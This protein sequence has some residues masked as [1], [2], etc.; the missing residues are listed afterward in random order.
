MESVAF[1]LWQRNRIGLWIVLGYWAAFSASLGL[2]GRRASAEALAIGILFVLLSYLFLVAVFIHQDSDVA[3]ARSSYPSYMFTLPVKTSRL[4]L[5]PMILGTVIVFAFCFVL[6]ASAR[7]SGANIPLF[8][9]AALATTFIAALQA[10]FWFPWGVPYAKLVL[11]MAVIALLSTGTGVALNASVPEWAICSA[12]SAIAGASYMTAYLGV[13][14]A[15]RGE[16][17]DIVS[18]RESARVRRPVKA[19]AAF[20][21]ATQA[22]VWYELRQHG[23]LLPAIA[24]ILCGLF[25]IPTVW[26]TT[27]SPIY[28]LGPDAEGKVPL[29]STYVMA[30]Y[31][32]LLMLLP[33]AAWVIGCG[34]KRS[35]VKR[36]DRTFQLFYGT[37]PMSDADLVGAKLKATAIS[38]L[39]AWAIV[40]VFS[41]PI[42]NMRGGSMNIRTNMF[43]SQDDRIHSVLAPFLDRQVLLLGFSAVLLLALMTW[44]NYAIGFWTELS[45]KL[46][47]RYAYPI[48]F[49]IGYA[50]I[51]VWGTQRSPDGGHSTA[52]MFETIFIGIWIALLAKLAISVWLVVKEKRT[53]LLRPSALAWSGAFFVTG[54]AVFV[55]T[56]LL[57]SQ[58][59]RQSMVSAQIGS[60]LVVDSTAIALFLLWT[61]LTR[62]L[63]APLML[64]INRHRSR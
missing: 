7:H 8:W 50:L 38:T 16:N 10:I 47:L 13:A 44:R 49:G 4:V 15:R 1:A 35:D 28:G 17:R 32:A 33:C 42:L 53:G 12:L 60:P 40:L 27:I 9:P 14:R 18:I 30:Y 54:A 20:R 57:L 59:L 21:S 25:Y 6:A 37:R 29:I 61:P 48:A 56:L 23:I 64:S 19:K 3:A 2:F 43:L 52:T 11:T 24:A 36:G 26:D 55:A 45:G 58:S 31:P 62:I 5:V 51:V 46:W 63:A 39:C 34:L 22:Q 41:L